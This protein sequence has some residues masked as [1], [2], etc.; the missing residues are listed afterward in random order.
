VCLKP[1]KTVQHAQTSAFHPPA[2]HAAHG[3]RVTAPLPTGRVR[4]WVRV[5][6]A[7]AVAGAGALSGRRTEAAALYAADVLS[8]LRG[9]AAKAGQM[10]GY[11][12]GFVPAGQ[13]AVFAKAMAKLQTAAHHS[14]PA[15]VRAVV[16]AELGRGLH[17]AFA[18]WSDTP[19]AS[20]S[21]GQVHRAR[22]HDGTRVAVKVQHPGVATALGNDLDNA[23]AFES[24]VARLVPAGVNIDELFQAVV[25]RFREELD[26]ELEA[27]NLSEFARL[28]AAEPAVQLPR[29]VSSHS[30]RRVL[31]T[32]FC[33]GESFEQAC[34]HAEAFR[35]HY[36]ETLWRFVT[37]SILR[38]GIFNA[39]PH[40]GNYLFNKDGKVVFL[41]FGCVQRLSKERCRLAEALRLAAVEREEARFAEAVQEWFGASKGDYERAAFR[42]MRLC[43]E[44]IFASPFRFT[45][46][47]AARVVKG[48][49]EF[50]GVMFSRSAGGVNF[51]SETVLL[52]RLQFG[53]Y[54]VLARLDVEVDYAVLDGAVLTEAANAG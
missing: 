54:S 14:D 44:P 26:Y 46:E 40:P 29:L 8:E 27:K 4:R 35:E 51:P 49:Q 41:D 34:R 5:T 47:F 43:F 13:S 31:T 42:F 28:H 20:A 37:R 38:G 22:L 12:D 39:D 48:L 1:A 3:V 23:A 18:E 53:F 25:E 33:H 50:K 21:I 45:P 30:S 10:S 7:C 32:L 15:A 2:K 6:K 36:A 19:F 16:E 9:L 17:D 52:N 24:M 11:V